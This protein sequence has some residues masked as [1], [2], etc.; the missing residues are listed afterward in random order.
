M[1]W[2]EMQRWQVR[3]DGSTWGDWGPEDQ[4]GRLNLLTEEQ[5]LKGVAEVVSGHAFCLSLPL[6]LPRGGVLNPNR[7]PPRIFPTRD[8]Q[9]P[10]YNIAWSRVDD[11]FVDIS[12]DDAVELTLQYSTQWDALAHVG[13]FFDVDGTGEEV[14][15][16]YNGFRAG[17]DVQGPTELATGDHGNSSY[18][19]K[20]GVENMAA[21]PIQGRAVL[22][23]LF[24]HLG[25]ARRPVGYDLLQQVMT[26]DSVVVEPGDMV[27]IRTGFAEHILSS[28][29][30]GEEVDYTSLCPV[31][32][33]S[34]PRLLE[35]ITE[36]GLVAL[37][38]DN[39]AVESTDLDHGPGRQS[40]MP[41]H[42]HCLFK[43][44]VI[45]GELWYLGELA[46][47]LR[48]NGR[49]RCLLTAPPLRLP[50]AVGS[51]A[52]AIATV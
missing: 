19:F 21:T 33:G 38:A 43:L 50:G 34:D 23:D 28:A 37:V 8:A 16:Y 2:R 39:Y 9:G 4:L 30:S 41:L 52:N 3:P 47:W 36:S 24:Y 46:A 26:E 51:P 42:H 14:P 48:G 35:W 13:A 5:R 45:I 32:D 11:R 25:S 12:A 18:A 6:D 17:T 49:N 40:V 7:R 20:L 44:G 31:L 10:R 22:I 1:D 29:Q 27:M 15:V